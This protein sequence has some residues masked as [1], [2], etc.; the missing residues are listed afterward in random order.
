MLKVCQFIE[1]LSKQDPKAVILVCGS[2][3]AEGSMVELQQM[4][5]GNAVPMK[6]HHTFYHRKISDIYEYESVESEGDK[7]WVQEHSFPCVFIMG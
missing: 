4:E 2:G 1:W 3:S 7:N 5:A 6:H